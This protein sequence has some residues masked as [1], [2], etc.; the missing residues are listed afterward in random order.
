ML[1]YTE[2]TQGVAMNHSVINAGAGVK[3]KVQQAIPV[4][5]MCTH[6]LY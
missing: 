2:Y 3:S 5:G 4:N 1:E 6:E